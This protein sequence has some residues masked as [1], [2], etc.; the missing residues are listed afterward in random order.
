[1][2]TQQ[3][4]PQP[5]PPPPKPPNKK[6][7]AACFFSEIKLANNVSENTANNATLLIAPLL[8]EFGM[9]KG[10]IFLFKMISALCTCVN[11]MINVF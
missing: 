11:I 10:K 1:M 3:Q 7:S 2:H 5:P 9:M 4:H 6:P 8:S